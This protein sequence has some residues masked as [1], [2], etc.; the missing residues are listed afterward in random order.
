MSSQKFAV[1]DQYNV[2]SLKLPYSSKESRPVD[3]ARDRDWFHG[4]SGQGLWSAEGRLRGLAK[5]GIY[6]VYSIGLM[7]PHQI[8]NLWIF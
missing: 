1:P 6:F 4:G 5:N 7:G 3:D 8:V 2:E